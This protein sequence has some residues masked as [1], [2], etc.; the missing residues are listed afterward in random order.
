MDLPHL[1]AP[2]APPEMFA[3]VKMLHFGTYGQALTYI[4]LLIDVYPE[5]L[6]HVMLQSASILL[7]FEWVTII[8]GRN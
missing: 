1:D 3:Y 6:A 4:Y 2:S 7:P 8:M 5:A